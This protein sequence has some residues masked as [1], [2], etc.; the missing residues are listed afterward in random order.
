VVFYAVVG[1][2]VWFLFWFRY[3]AS[4]FGLIRVKNL[5]LNNCC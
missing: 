3:M 2:V 4:E 1:S 5:F